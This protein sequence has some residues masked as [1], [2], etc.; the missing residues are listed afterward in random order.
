MLSEE[1]FGDGDMTSL[2]KDDMA[3]FV[4]VDMESFGDLVSFGEG[5]MASFDKADM[6]PIMPSRPTSHLGSS[7]PPSLM[8]KPDESE[9]QHGTINYNN[10]PETT[11]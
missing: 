3:S 10:E 2:G 11:Y 5:D 4:K 1:E 6:T 7:S 8:W 9:P